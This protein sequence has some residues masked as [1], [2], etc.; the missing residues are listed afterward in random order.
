MTGPWVSAQCEWD[1]YVMFRSTRALRE[2]YLKLVS[3]CMLCFGAREVM[4]FLGNKL[5]GR[6]RAKIVSDITEHRKEQLPGMTSN[7]ERK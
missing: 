4:D 3:H 2:L 6:F 7:T 5:V 1:T